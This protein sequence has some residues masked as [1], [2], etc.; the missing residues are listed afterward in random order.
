MDD[1]QIEWFFDRFK[2]LID[3][4]ESACDSEFVLDV[5]DDIRTEIKFI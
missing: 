3:T 5:L 2:N 4:L 1:S